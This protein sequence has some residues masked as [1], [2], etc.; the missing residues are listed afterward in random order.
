MMPLPLYC[1]IVNARNF[2]RGRPLRLA[3][4]D[5]EAIF[6]ASD[7]TGELFLCRR[8]RHLRYKRGIGRLLEQ[9]VRA[10]HLQHVSLGAG[11]LLIDCGANVG[12]LGIWARSRNVEYVA[13]ERE[14]VEARCVD[15]NAY[16]GEPKTI[17]KALWNRDTTLEFFSKPDTA[18]S[19]VIDPGDTAER[20]TVDAVRLDT[21]LDLSGRTGMVVLKVE[22]EGAEPEILDGAT[23]LLPFVDFV[24]VDC[25]PERGRQ[26]A[27]TFVEVNGFLV[28]AGFRLVQFGIPRTTA[29]YRNAG[30]SQGG[31][32]SAAALDD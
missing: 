6:K 25:G 22:G 26:E 20:R 4:F 10:Y 5:G 17:R 16:G 27:H 9:L 19:S 14:P 32:L 7:A 8:G 12:E 28:E 1:R 2:L 29:L 11:G 24:T 13:F 31:T 30:R 15:L 21:A 18:D 23:G 3:P